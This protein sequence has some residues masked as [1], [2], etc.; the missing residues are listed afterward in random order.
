MQTSSGHL[1]SISRTV[2][3]GVMKDDLRFV[4][5]MGMDTVSAI[6]TAELRGLES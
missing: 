2:S 5:D 3:V 1:L 4:V 6:D